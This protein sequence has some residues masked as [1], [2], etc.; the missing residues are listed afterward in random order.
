MFLCFR[1]AFFDYLHTKVGKIKFGMYLFLIYWLN[2]VKNT[3]RFAI[4]QIGMYKV[5]LSRELYP[6]FTYQIEKNP[7][8]YVYTGLPRRFAPRNDREQ[9]DCHAYLSF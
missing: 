6:N 5:D 4:K 3:Y 7:F 9:M 1:G 8:W 2:S